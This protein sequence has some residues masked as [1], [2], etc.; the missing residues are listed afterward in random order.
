MPYT[1]LLSALPSAPPAAPAPPVR[2]GR[3]TRLLRATGGLALAC[4]GAVGV[5][6][7][8][9][10]AHGSPTALVEPAEALGTGQPDGGP[11]GDL[12]RR[13]AAA[14][15]TAG[16]DD[17]PTAATAPRP[18]PSP[19]VGEVGLA[20]LPFVPF[21][22]KRGEYLGGVRLGLWPAER[23]TVA[24]PAYANPRGFYVVTPALRG[25]RVSPHFALGEFAMHEGAR[26][27]SGETYVALHEPLLQ[28]LE[29]VLADLG[30]HGLG[31]RDLRVLSGFRAPRYNR[32]VEGA[33]PASRH[34]FG[35]AADVVVD[36]DGDG[37]M[38][39]LNADGRVDRRDLYLVADAVERVERAAPQLVGGLGLYDATGPSG[40]FLHVDVRG[41]AARWGTA[42]RGGGDA[43]PAPPIWAAPRRSAAVVL[44]GRSCQATGADTILCVR[45]GR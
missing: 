4:V 19:A 16:E 31:A 32:G 36:G 7:V 33:A 41:R 8:A 3:A 38:D 44:G 6:L 13:D 10:L 34:Q 30:A 39:D 1:P 15:L 28:K 18:A 14:H 21:A 43:T 45:R 35:D 2:G 40:P 23:R 27:A 11:A 42:S 5:G 12:G 17:G 25:H 9:Q 24:D 26:G 29:L 22:V 37:R 20:G